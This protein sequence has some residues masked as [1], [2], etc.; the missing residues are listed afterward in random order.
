[1]PR[2]R[3]SF[4]SS[5]NNAAAQPATPKLDLPAKPS[6]KSTARVPIAKIDTTVAAADGQSPEAPAAAPAPTPLQIVPSLLEKA[7]KAVGN[8]QPPAKQVAAADPT[9]TATTPESSGGYAVQLAA[10]GT[11]REAQSASARLQAK[12]G[13]ELGGA[14]LSIRQADHDGKTVYRVRAGNLSKADAVALCQK[15]KASGGDS[16]CFIAKN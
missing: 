15:L 9:A 16:A 7:V 3:P 4:G 5:A 11:E 2:A 10:P 13:A 1:V 14:Q 6:A 12:Y 8:Q